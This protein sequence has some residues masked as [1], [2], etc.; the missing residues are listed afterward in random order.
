MKTNYTIYGYA[1]SLAVFDFA[2]LLSGDMMMPGMLAV[3]GDFR[4]SVSYIS[5]VIS[6][7][8]FGNALLSLFLGYISQILGKKLVIIVGNIVFLIFTILLSVSNNIN[9]FILISI[10][11]G[12]AAS[13]I[14]V[15][16]A[17]LHEKLT[18][19]MVVKTTSMMANVEVI[20]LIFGPV[21]GV[22]VIKYLSWRYILVV[23]V[24]I[25]FISLFGMFKY[26]DYQ[27]YKDD[28]PRLKLSSIGFEYL[29]L[30]ANSKF[31][32]GLICYT[33]LI[34]PSEIWVIF[35][36]ILIL[37]TLKLSD[38]IYM[39][40]QVL[41]MSG[42]LLGS[43]MV[44]YV[45]DYLDLRKLIILGVVISTIG[46]ILVALGASHLLIVA[47]GLAICFIGYGLQIDIIY[48][49]VIKLSSRYQDNIIMIISF[50]E[51]ILTAIIIQFANFI[52][53]CYEYSLFS[54]VYLLLGIAVITYV[55]IGVFMFQNQQYTW[56]T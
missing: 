26:I 53:K 44:Q 49:M 19:K 30:F 52:F 27:T 14:N 41:V 17:F 13:C 33:L 22:M 21:L 34:I 1:I 46:Y 32:V 3:V 9:F 23:C 12:M 42:F 35:S 7:Y 5:I 2:I 8:L 16:F 4:V 15:G 37:D 29:R 10:F 6:S 45:V 24:I 36:P 38:S 47:L 51:I 48:R 11:Q 43:I 40:D 31:L 54:F 56:D 28:K 55:I 18:D 50:L 25:G 20:S 39:I